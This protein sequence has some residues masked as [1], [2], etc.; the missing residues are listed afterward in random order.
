MKYY[1]VSDIHGYYTLFREALEDAG[2]FKETE[3]HKLI[4]CGDLLDRG[5]E[6]KEI[7]EFVLQ[8]MREDRVILIR[9]NHEDLMER[10]VRDLEEDMLWNIVNGTSYHI[11]N[12][13]WD[14]ALQLAEMEKSY[15]LVRPRVLAA[16]VKASDFWQKIL[17]ATVNYFETEHYVFVHG[18]IPCGSNTGQTVYRSSVQYRFNP[19]WREASNEDFA[20]AR[21]YNG[22][23]FA[24]RRGLT[25][26]DKTIV[27]GHWHTSYGHATF[28]HK[29]SEDGPDADFSPFIDDGI[30]AID[31]CTKYSGL[32]NCIVLED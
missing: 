4:I 9:G 6:A 15:A 10:L 31:A 30:I 1:V 17:P 18:W 22:M 24:C 19:N 25:L 3:P 8:L 2:F 16:R 12:G 29:G 5:Q 27:C 23:E 32:V 20:N 26:R 7:V 11:H 28:H 14:T 13:T 21:W